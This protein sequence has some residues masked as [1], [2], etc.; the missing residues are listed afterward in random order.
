M[1]VKLQ[2]KIW[3]HFY[4]KWVRC[5]FGYIFFEKKLFILFYK[6]FLILMK[7][8]FSQ[9]WEFEPDFLCSKLFSNTS[10]IIPLIK[11]KPKLSAH[12]RF[13]MTI[14]YFYSRLSGV[15]D[16]N[17]SYN[18]QKPFTP[19]PPHDIAIQRVHWRGSIRIYRYDEDNSLSAISHVS[20][21]SNLH[22][23]FAQLDFQWR[24][25]SCSSFQSL[26]TI[27]IYVCVNILHIFF[28]LFSF[29]I[30]RKVFHSF[31]FRN[32]YKPSL[33]CMGWLEGKKKSRTILHHFSYYF[34]KKSGRIILW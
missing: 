16:N 9:D 24:C 30:G 2:R 25:C 32:G 5:T 34:C 6:Y 27:S 23:I 19:S 8:Y 12:T 11:P 13:G 21:F 22:F 29:W 26:S 14:I 15:R 3:R 7:A 31:C 4:G 10:F 33:N 17:F 18:I 1:I 20:L 28:Q